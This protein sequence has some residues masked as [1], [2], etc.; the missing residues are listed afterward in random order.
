MLMILALFSIFF[1][2]ITKDMFIGLGSGFFSDN[3]L[4]IHPSHEIMLDTEFGVPT[5]FKLLPLLFT[6]SLSVI[7][8]VLSEYLSTILIYFKLSR[9]GYNIFSFFNQ[10]FLI[11]L[12]YNRYI[13]GIILK[14]GGQ[15]TKV[16][17]KGSVEHLGPHGLEKG[18]LNIS[19]NI[20]RLNTG[21][22]TSYALYILI[23]LIFY[24][25]FN[26]YINNFIIILALV[27]CSSLV[28][29]RADAHNVTFYQSNVSGNLKDFILWDFYKLFHKHKHYIHK[30]FSSIITLVILIN[31]P[32]LTEMNK[33]DYMQVLL[34]FIVVFFIFIHNSI[35]NMNISYIYSSFSLT[36]VPGYI[37]SKFGNI[38]ETSI[39]PDNVSCL[40]LFI[41]LCMLITNAILYKSNSFSLLSK[42]KFLLKN[43]EYFVFIFTG[44]FLVNII[45]AFTGIAIPINITSFNLFILTVFCRV[46]LFRLIFLGFNYY[47]TREIHMNLLCMSL[48]NIL[49]IFLIFYVNI[50]FVLPFIHECIHHS[51]LYIDIK[52]IK[53]SSPSAA[54][55]AFKGLDVVIGSKL[56]SLP[57]IDT[58]PIPEF[59]FSRIDSMLLELKGNITESRIA[60]VK[61]SIKE[62]FDQLKLQ[63]AIAFKTFAPQYT[64][65]VGFFDELAHVHEFDDLNPV[66]HRAFELMRQE[67]PKPSRDLLE[68]DAI[69]Y[70]EQSVK[71]ANRQHDNTVQV[72]SLIKHYVKQNDVFST[73]DKTKLFTALK[74]LQRVSNNIATMDKD[75]FN[76][77]IKSSKILTELHNIRSK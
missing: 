57:K 63:G 15:T 7:A 8:I 31:V 59:D 3:A 48:Q 1:G 21:L 61:A 23:G 72:L 51:K 32:L 16:I 35:K 70:W 74:N 56:D 46:V 45:L 44:F 11:E 69:R 37:D 10:R 64:K 68:D 39:I 6:I 30:Q 13:T 20:A 53:C 33:V 34:I 36:I 52:Y 77:N 60:N 9:V 71:Y 76:Q 66:M 28:L 75:L 38:I 50:L 27:T 62:N 26:S 73:Q 47:I 12:F 65:V 43:K 25:L 54:T 19:N 5:L 24:L 17:D 40:L 58:T 42:L 22:T 41:G 18:L 4:F 29:F 49:V 67:I 14:L 55:A 2:F